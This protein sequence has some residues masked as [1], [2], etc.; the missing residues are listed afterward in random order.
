[1]WWINVD[2]CN[3]CAWGRLLWHCWSVEQTEACLQ[4]YNGC[5]SAGVEIRLMHVHTT[6]EWDALNIIYDEW[7]AKKCAFLCLQIFL[8]STEF[9]T[10]ASGVTQGTMSH[11]TYTISPNNS[12]YWFW[13]WQIALWINLCVISEKVLWVTGQSILNS[14]T[15]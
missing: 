5:V 3:G 14:W 12:D 4:A 13:S 1:M 2:M 11:N 9:Y 8:Q 10:S 15:V 6:S 7:L